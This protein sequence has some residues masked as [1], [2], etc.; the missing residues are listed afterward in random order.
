MATQ[1]CSV[2]SLPARPAGKGCP[3][4]GERGVEKE[5]GGTEKDGGR[6]KRGKGFNERREKQQGRGCPR[7]S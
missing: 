5:R 7:G 4:K 2:P 6:G 3:R 1:K